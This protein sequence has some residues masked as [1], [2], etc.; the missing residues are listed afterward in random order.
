MGTI[1]IRCPNTGRV[2]STGKDVASAAAFRSGA[3]FFSRTYC[4]HCRVTHEWFA[5]DAWIREPEIAVSD[6]QSNGGVMDRT[7]ARLN[8]EH[9][10]KKLAT[11]Q[12]ETKQQ[13]L[14]R[15]LVEEQA[16]L[17]A[18]DNPPERKRHST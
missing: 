9:Y 17:A 11:E 2:I 10:Q 8:I 14:M 7:V 5:Q 18:L 16:K 6:L 4:P 15:L 13:T 3:V 1:M 12:D